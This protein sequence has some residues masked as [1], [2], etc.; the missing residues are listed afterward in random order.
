M[1]DLVPHRPPMLLLDE[2]KEEGDG[3]IRCAA[4]PRAD[5][6]LAAGGTA[7]A[8]LALE[9]MAQSVAAYSGLYAMR[10]S[11][12]VQRG[13]IIGVRSMSL[14]VPD[15]EIGR[16]LIV[17]ARHV[18]GDSSLG[19][20]DCTVEE[21]GTAREVASAALTVFQGDLEEGA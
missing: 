12:P 7:P 14:A 4:T 16:K 8:I 2:V 10:R 1:L 21:A 20:F 17:T 19:K 13:Y 6:P 5:F 11:L 3:V 15:L 9:Y 18:W